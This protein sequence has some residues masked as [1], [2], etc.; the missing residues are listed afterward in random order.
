MTRPHARRRLRLN[1]DHLEDRRTPAV[2]AWDGGPTGD[3]TDFLLAANRVGDVL[4]AA[5]DD[6]TIVLS[7][8]GTVNS[9]T[10]SRVLQIRGISGGNVTLTATAGV[11]NTGTLELT[12][13]AN[14][15]ATLTVN[16]GTLTNAPGATLRTLPG[17]GNRSILLGTGVDFVSRGAV[18]ADGTL[19]LNVGSGRSSFDSPGRSPSPADGP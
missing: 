7:A 16:G 12:S 10:N 19:T 14:A 18:A 5:T 17:G 4:P 13:N 6:V 1:L 2:I 8:V 11:T 9:I 3:G 15:S